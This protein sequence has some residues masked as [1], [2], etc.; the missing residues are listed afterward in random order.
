[1]H[2]H[3][4]RAQTHIHVCDTFT[5]AEAIV[6]SASLFSSHAISGLFKRVR[7][8]PNVAF[9]AACEV[10]GLGLTL[11]TAGVQATFQIQSK[12]A[13]N[14]RRGVGGDL[15]VVRAFSDGCQTLNPGRDAMCDGYTG[16]TAP[17]GTALAVLSSTSAHTQACSDA[18]TCAPYPPQVGSLGANLLGDVIAGGSYLGEVTGLTTDEPKFPVG[19]Y[20]DGDP[21]ITLSV[22]EKLEDHAY[23]GATITLSSASG[24]TCAANGD[25]KTI[26][27]YDSTSRKATL[28]STLSSEDMTNCEYKI[29][30]SKTVVYLASPASSV[31]GA[32]DQYRVR[33]LPGAASYGC[34]DRWTSVTA[35]AGHVSLSDADTVVASRAMLLSAQTTAWLSGSVSSQT[36]TTVLNIG[37]ASPYPRGDLNGVASVTIGG[38]GTGYTNGGTATFTNGGGSGAAGTCTTATVGGVAGVITGITITNAGSGYTSAPTVTCDGT[39]TDATLTA[40]LTTGNGALEASTLVGLWITVR[41]SLGASMGTSKIAAAVP[42]AAPTLTVTPALSAATGASTYVIHGWDDGGMPCQV[43]SST[44]RAVELIPANCNRIIDE[45][46]LAAVASQTQVTL[47]A[48][49]SLTASAYAGYY[50]EVDGTGERRKISTYTAARVATVSDAFTRSVG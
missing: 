17:D 39:N 28:D 4:S 9:A 24:Q 49:A 31:S 6:P 22:G 41:D 3:G 21:S 25:S 37:L 43:D 45:G 30:A 11:S 35:Y 12:D 16:T 26:V 1:M 23:V 27:A 13:Y 19:T 50:L 2:A 8:N 20:T 42:L 46:R 18:A 34:E 15:F 47:G 7:V 10:H 33:F 14:N 36:S 29:T 44:A 5:Q 38:G 48:S 40:V 32:Y